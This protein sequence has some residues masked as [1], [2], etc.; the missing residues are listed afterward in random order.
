MGPLLN[1]GI[2]SAGFDTTNEL[3]RIKSF[4]DDNSLMTSSDDLCP[5]CGMRHMKELL[6]LMGKS[7][8]Y[9]RS[10][11]PLSLSEWSFTVCPTP[12]NRK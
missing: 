2:F 12:Y 9:G 6:L 5:V 10:G 3:N 11:F 4:G 1:H 8:P 7:S